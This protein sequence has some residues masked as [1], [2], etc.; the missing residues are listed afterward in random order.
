MST[1]PELEELLRKQFAF[2][3]GKK[4]ADIHPDSLV[5][6]LVQETKESIQA[7]TAQAVQEAM[8][9]RLD[10]PFHYVEP[11]EPDCSPERHAYHQGQWDMAVRMQTPLS[12]QPQEE[13]VKDA[14]KSCL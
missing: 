1:S 12:T 7:H 11:C 14:K 10:L 3:L 13:E 9:N 5:E 8:L 4:A 6:Q 2:L